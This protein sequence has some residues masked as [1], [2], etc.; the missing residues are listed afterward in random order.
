MVRLLGGRV[1]R[2]DS[3][4]PISIISSSEKDEEKSEER[5]DALE[6]IQYDRTR[7]MRPRRIPD[8]SSTDTQSPSPSVPSTTAH[9]CSTRPHI[10]VLEVGTSVLVPRGHAFGVEVIC[11]SPAR[12]H[13]LYLVARHPDLVVRT[14]WVFNERELLLVAL[15][16]LQ[17]ALLRHVQTL[18]T[19]PRPASQAL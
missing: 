8:R 7:L 10:R 3:K 1:Y 6:A 19:S 16:L 17:H 15:H 18:E 11:D 2:C 4:N 12:G 5:R 13:V 9:H 14:L